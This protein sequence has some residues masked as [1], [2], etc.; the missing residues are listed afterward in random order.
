MK[1]ERWTGPVGIPL[2]YSSEVGLKGSRQNLDRGSRGYR[3][4][5]DARP[6]LRLVEAFV[7]GEDHHV[8]HVAQGKQCL[9][10][11]NSAFLHRLDRENPEKTW[12]TGHWWR[13]PGEEAVVG[14][15][16]HEGYHRAL[17]P[18]SSHGPLSFFFVFCTRGTCSRICKREG[19]KREW[20]RRMDGCWG[21]E[22]GWLFP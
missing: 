22:A 11:R 15:R 16:S 6:I 20:R 19:E 14:A 2:G 18:V 3:E 17:Y 10:K 12:M 7:K 4:N 1:S 21:R 13:G 8:D 9:S 5:K